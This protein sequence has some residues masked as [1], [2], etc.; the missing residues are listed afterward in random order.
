MCMER[1]DKMFG[2]VQAD[3]ASHGEA[4]CFREGKLA[5]EQRNRIHLS[6]FHRLSNRTASINSCSLLAAV[7]QGEKDE[8]KMDG[9]LHGVVL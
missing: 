2:H 1:I 4:V 5:K 3:V 7:K 9:F 6:H 8:K